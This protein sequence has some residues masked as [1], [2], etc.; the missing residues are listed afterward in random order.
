MILF[1]LGGVLVDASFDVL[2]QLVAQPMDIDSMRQRWLSSSAVRDFEIGALD[3]TGFARRFLDEWNVDMPEQRFIE[4]FEAWPAG[5]YPGAGDLVAR[6]RKNHRV[7][8]FSNCNEL[9]WHAF[10]PFLDWF[11]VAISSHEIGLAKPD[12]RAFENAL[13]LAGSE[14]EDTWFFD[15]SP[16]NIVAAASLGMRAVRTHRLEQLEAALES[17]GLLTARG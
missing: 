11:D 6:V 5:P 15:D 1:D 14:P 12:V 17:E 3:P 10:G 7:G 13:R 9:H 16:S 8:C 2:G 4:E